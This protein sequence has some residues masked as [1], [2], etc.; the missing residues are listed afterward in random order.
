M[1]ALSLTVRSALVSSRGAGCIDVD[2]NGVDVHDIKSWYD[3]V[4]EEL[5]SDAED[6]ILQ[7]E[8]QLSDLLDEIESLKNQLL[9]AMEMLEDNNE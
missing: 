7:L 5:L 3:L 2:L 8:V 9:E 4:D 1:S 6:M